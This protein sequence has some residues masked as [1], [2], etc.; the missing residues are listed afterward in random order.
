MQIQA[1]QD[2][3]GDPDY[4]VYYATLVHT[5]KLGHVEILPRMLVGVDATGKIDHLSKYSDEHQRQYGSPQAYMRAIVG[6]NLKL[7]DLSQ[8]PFQF[9]FPG[10]VDT[11]IHASQYPNIGIGCEMPLLDWLKG[12][13]FALESRFAGEAPDKLGFA[14]DVYSRVIDKTLSNGTTCASYFTTIDT[15]TSKLFASLLVEK[16]QR[17]FVGKVCMDH[18]PDYPTYQ[19]SYDDCVEGVAEII[20]HCAKLGNP[21]NGLALVKPIITPRFAPLCLRKLMSQLG[22]ISKTHELPVQTHIS[23]NKQEIALVAKMF[24]ESLSYADVYDGHGLLGRRTILA[25]AVHLDASE[26]QLVRDRECSLSHC[27]LSNTFLASGEAPV[28]QY[29]YQDGINVSLG[30]DLSGGYEQS[31]LGVARSLIMVSHHRAMDSPEGE[32]E[33]RLGVADALYMATMGGA[34]ACTMEGEIGSFEEG[35]YFDAQLV[36][37]S[38]GNSNIDVFEH[39]TPRVGDG[40]YEHRMMQLLQRWVFSGDDRNCVKVWCNGRVVVDKGEPWVYL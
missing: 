34:R 35:K 29:L 24:P 6:D 1:N 38:S 7:V 13:T 27:P 11:H 37:L 12:Y 14:C 28:R 33:Q 19:E 9:I 30:T 26:R 2:H 31:I 20:D 22:E 40:D 16:G 36:N 15:D 17:G 5:P 18:N 25:H 8:N 21:A 3:K 23:E 39:Q 10:F 4:T 32:P